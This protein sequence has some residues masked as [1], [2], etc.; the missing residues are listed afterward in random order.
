MNKNFTILDL[1]KTVKLMKKVK[2]NEGTLIYPHSSSISNVTIF[3]YNDAAYTNLCDEVS[4]ANGHIIFLQNNNKNCILSWSST[5]IKRIAESSTTA[6]CFARIEEIEGT[7]YL[8]ALLY[9]ILKLKNDNL[10][11]IA[12]ID[13]KNLHAL[14]NSDKLSQ[15][16]RLR[17]DI[18]AI[19]EMIKTNVIQN[20]R[21]IQ[22]TGQLANCLTK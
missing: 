14:I 1:L 2:V 3:V 16:R 9:Y 21:W 11:I 8:K 15:Y 19:K 10:P 18:A 7:L 4:N 20:V 13:N 6:E 17:T 5:R 12:M 22:S